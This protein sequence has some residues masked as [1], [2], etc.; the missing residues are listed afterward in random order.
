MNDPG[1]N[2]QWSKEKAYVQGNIVIYNGV[3][4]RAK[5]WVKGETPDTSQAWEPIGGT[6]TV[7]KNWNKATIYVAGDT[8]TYNDVTYQAKWWNKGEEPTRSAAWKIKG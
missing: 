7:K 1:S 8:V 4:Y 3:T 2:Q 5:W 6:N